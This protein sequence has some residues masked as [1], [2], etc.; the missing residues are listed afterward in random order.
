MEPSDLVDQYLAALD[1]QA[2]PPSPA[3]L[4]TIVRRH[5]ATFSF[6]SLGPRLGDALPLD[7]AALF[8]R[9]VV[10]RRGGYCFE[11]NGLLFAVL[12]ELGYTPRLQLA[13]V[14]HNTDQLPGLTHRISLVSLAGVDHV[15]DVGFGPSGPPV[16]VPMPTDTDPGDDT[17]SRFRVVA[18]GAGQYHL[19]C[20]KDGA[21]YSLYRFDT[22]A[23]GQSDC[24]LGHFYSH[25][26]PNAVFVNHLDV[27][28]IHD[29][30]V[31]SLRKRGFMVLDSSGA[32]RDHSAIDDAPTLT[33]LLRHRFD[34][35]VTDDEGHRLFESMPT[36]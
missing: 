27:S 10:R 30:A 2:G 12:T 33:A 1:V 15:V 13:R 28:R 25:R 5:V 20:R 7:P 34:L 3:Q 11:Q 32:P 17:W 24:E 31:W 21:P 8:D 18:I 36:D 9:I 14:I 16:P 4:A 19:Q 22:G 26:H 6:A 35:D 23:F 29:D